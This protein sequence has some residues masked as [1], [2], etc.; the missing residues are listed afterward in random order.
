MLKHAIIFTGLMLFV[1]FAYSQDNPYGHSMENRPSGTGGLE[2]L[3]AIIKDFRVN[4]DVGSAG[5]G[6]PAIAVDGAGNFVVVWEDARNDDGDIY[7]QRYAADGSALGANFKVNDDSGSVRQGEPAIAMDGH[8]NFVVVWE[9]YRNGNADIYAQRYD[10]DGHALGTNFKVNDDS[11]SVDQRFPA[12]G[13]DSAGN[14][15][16]VWQDERNGHADIFAQR[17][18]ANGSVLDVNFQI[19]DDTGSENHVGPAIAVDGKGNFM[20]VWE[21]YRNG[22][23][24]IYA[25]RY[26]ID[27]S[28]IGASFKV[29]DDSVSARQFEPAITMDGAGNFVVVWTD[30]RND[31]GDIYLQ[32][33]AADG[34]TLSTN[35]KVNDDTE[36]AWQEYPSIAMDSVGNFVVTWQDGRNN[37]WDLYAQRYAANGTGF[38]TNFIVTEYTYKNQYTPDVKIWHGRIFTT[39]ASTH[40][41]G[42]GADIWANVLDWN[43]PVGIESKATFVVKTFELRQN[44]PNPFNAAT[45][46]TYSLFTSAPIELTIYNFLGQ[47]VRTLVKK[48]QPAGQYQINW[49]GKDEYGHDVV[50][51]VYLY[52]LKTGDFTKTKKMILLK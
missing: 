13:V 1:S 35:L 4:D 18:A 28:A 9:D 33:Y 31:K 48:S 7:A 45:T 26:A 22:D 51:G 12:I 47:K 10:A 19:N 2:E 8:G 43:N 3:Q 46:I 50:S 20:I 44:Y 25:R 40:A 32:R 17:Y 39:W 21:D 23:T 15:V 34:S 29:N 16:V 30:G 24:D 11:G 38:G 52:Q 42:K 37:T 5:Q 27:G 41:S 6:N 14:V 49:D 36:S